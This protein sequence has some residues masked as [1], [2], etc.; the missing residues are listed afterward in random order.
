MES[1]RRFFQV[2]NLREVAHGRDN[3]LNL[4]RFICASAVIVSHSWVLLGSPD[5]AQDFFR[6]CNLGDIAVRSFF[7][8]SGYLILKSGLRGSDAEEFLAARVL[9][10]FPGLIVAVLACA[11]LLGPFASTLSLRDYFLNPGTWT[12]L[13]EMVLHRTQDPLPGVFRQGHLL[14]QVDGVFWTLPVEWTM[15]IVTLVLCLIIRGKNFWGKSPVQTL[16]MAIAALGLTIQMMP[17]A[18]PPRIKSCVFYFVFGAICY[19]IRKWIPLSIPAALLLL[20]TDLILIG[21]RGYDTGTRLF[22]L[23]LGYTLLTFGFHPAA[24]VKS[25]HKLGDYSYGLYIYAFPIQQLTISYTHQSLTLLAASYPSSLL[26]AVISWH[27]IEKPC[28]TIKDRFKQKRK[29]LQM[30]S[31]VVVR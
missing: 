16:L 22:P 31:E 1:P 20:G 10:I 25:F 29:I 5:P 27:Y 3:N 11:F 6:S 28:L 4:I 18:D 12:F 21:T 23:A 2:A 15:Y 13:R 7:F 30:E 17:L 9:R 14:S 24:I 19:S 8:L 26:A